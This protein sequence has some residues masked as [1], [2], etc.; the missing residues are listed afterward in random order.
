MSIARIA[1]GSLASKVA[2]PSMAARAISTTAVAQKDVVQELY[3][4]E[5]KGYKPAPVKAD[6]SQVKDL[7]LPPAPEAPKVDADLDQQLAAY[8][9]APEASQ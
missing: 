9:N 4:K 6:E 3:L 7:K 5:L 8:N 1:F 2:A